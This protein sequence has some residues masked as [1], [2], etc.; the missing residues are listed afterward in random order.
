[1]ADMKKEID[2]IKKKNKR[3]SYA[4]TPIKALHAL[5]VNPKLAQKEK[6]EINKLIMK[7]DDF[8]GDADKRKRDAMLNKVDKEAKALI[9]KIDTKYM[10]N[11]ALGKATGGKVATTKKKKK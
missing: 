7:V 2:K 5:V 10:L 3:L 6:T 4:T 9:K 8:K 11:K 1:M